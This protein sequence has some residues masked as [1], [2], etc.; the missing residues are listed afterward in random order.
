MTT[1]TRARRRNPDSIRH[2][3]KRH[4]A[5]A[6]DAAGRKAARLAN[7]LYPDYSVSLVVGLRMDSQDVTITAT[8]PGPQWPAVSMPILAKDGSPAIALAVV[9]DDLQVVRAAMKLGRAILARACPDLAN[10]AP[11]HLLISVD[12]ERASIGTTGAEHEPLFIWLVP[13]EDAAGN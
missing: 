3:I 7:P 11:A 5:A 8:R 9:G 10:D 13:A 6:F 2:P 1:A 4:E 12:G